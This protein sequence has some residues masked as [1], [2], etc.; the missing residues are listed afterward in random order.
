MLYAFGFDRIGVLVS[1][2]YFV[3]PNPGKARKDPN[4]GSAW[5]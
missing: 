5:R 1:D 4:G 2:L 3:D